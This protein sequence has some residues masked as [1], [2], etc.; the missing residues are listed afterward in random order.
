MTREY[1]E[2]LYK[3]SIMDFKSACN[4]DEQWKARHDMAK[5]ERFAIEQFGYEFVETVLGD[6][7]KD[8]I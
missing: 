8:L 4:D 3:Q 1:I 7:K 2:K 6:L 5:L